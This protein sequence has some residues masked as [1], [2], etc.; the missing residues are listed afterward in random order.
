[1]RRSVAYSVVVVEVQRA[2]YGGPSERETERAHQVQRRAGVRA[3]A[4]DI[5]GIGRD[6]RPERDDVER[7][8]LLPFI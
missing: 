6:F 1:M 3:Q 7:Q 5:A 8:S 4:D 2:W